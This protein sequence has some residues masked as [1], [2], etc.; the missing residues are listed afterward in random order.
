MIEL[1]DCRAIIGRLKNG[2]DIWMMAQNPNGWNSIG[3]L[4]DMRMLGKQW[5]EVLL[6]MQDKKGYRLYYVKAGEWNGLTEMAM[7]DSSTTA[8]EEEKAKDAKKTIRKDD[9]DGIKA[10][11][12]KLVGEGKI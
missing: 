12:E 2:A 10:L 3:Q 7:K 4:K 6:D 1:K 8:E 11:Y 9:Y 5:Y